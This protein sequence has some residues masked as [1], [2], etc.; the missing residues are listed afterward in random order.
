MKKYVLTESQV[1]RVI[2][3]LINEQNTSA[4]DRYAKKQ[5]DSF[6]FVYNNPKI[7]VCLNYPI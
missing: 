3:Q 7:S 2:D 4:E 1:K 6:D 5:R